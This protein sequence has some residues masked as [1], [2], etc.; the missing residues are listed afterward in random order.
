MEFTSCG[1][2]DGSLCGNGTYEARIA[3]NL[4]SAQGTF[5]YLKEHEEDEE[6]VHPY[7]TQSE[8]DREERP[9]QYIAN[10]RNGSTAGFKYFDLQQLKK[11]SVRTRSE[12]AGSMEVRIRTDGEAIAVIP[13]E[14][15]QEWKEASASADLVTGVLPL[16]FTWNGSGSCDFESFMLL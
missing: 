6:K 9:D 3:C 1:L 5:P 14:P 12:S 10:M 2:N 13:V 11:V 8:E 16:Y 7:F 15:S 4:Y